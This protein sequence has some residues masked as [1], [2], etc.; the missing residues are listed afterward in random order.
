MLSLI[1]R[2]WLIVKPPLAPLLLT[3][4]Q[5][6]AERVRASLA[7][8][9]LPS[10]KNIRDIF[11]IPHRGQSRKK[12]VLFASCGVCAAWCGIAWCVSH[13]RLLLTAECMTHPHNSSTQMHFSSSSKGTWGCV[14]CVFCLVHRVE[15]YVSQWTRTITISSLSCY[16]SFFSISCSWVCWRFTSEKWEQSTL[17]IFCLLYVLQNVC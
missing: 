3:G 16:T 7:W 2:F 1:K 6:S 12:V 8:Y 10:V 9:K 4:L 15:A 17:Y 14:L 13:H 5:T 11:P